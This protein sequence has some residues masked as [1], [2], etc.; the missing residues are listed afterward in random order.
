MVRYCATTLGLVLLASVLTAQDASQPPGSLRFS[1]ALPSNVPSEAVQIRYFATGPQ[2]GYGSFLK[3]RPRLEAYE[4]DAPGTRVKV[5]A[6]LPGCQF[7]TLDLTA[8]MPTAQQLDCRPLRSVTLS[9]RIIPTNVLAGN[10]AKVEASYLAAWSHELFGIAD[11]RVAEFRVATAAPS[12]DGTFELSL[13]D[14]AEDAVSTC[15]KLKAEWRFLLREAGTGNILATLEPV[16][17]GS[18]RIG[19]EVRPSYPEVVTFAAEPN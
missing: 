12:E 13:P 2:G 16:E 3:P 19:L 4:L 18:N 7:D 11:G 9:G 8:D 1:L 17:S 14:F 5:I 10:A 15:W 6:Y